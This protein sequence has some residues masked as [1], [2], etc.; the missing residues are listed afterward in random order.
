MCSEREEACEGTGG[1]R[2]Q[3]KRFS[4]FC[5]TEKKRGVGGGGVDKLPIVLAPKPVVWLE[6]VKPQ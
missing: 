3:K 6:E 4:L 1:E 5:R 2:A